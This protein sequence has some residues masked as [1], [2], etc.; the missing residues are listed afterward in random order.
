MDA[1]G[2]RQTQIKPLN[3]G[4]PYF[5]HEGKLIFH[6]AFNTTSEDICIA[7]IDGSNMIKLTN[8]KATDLHPEVSADGKQI[9]FMSNRDGNFEI[10][11]MNI[12]GSNQKRLT[13][14][15]VDDWDPSWSPDGAKILFQSEDKHG[16]K[17]IYKMN[18]DGSSVEKFIDN[19]FGAV[20]LK[21]HK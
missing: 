11:V 2:S 4:G 14:N 21:T 6:S 12:D 13:N 5:T 8:N 16:E 17:H 3:G 15:D 19:A 1:D 20:W 18:N 9:V 10:Y 7:N